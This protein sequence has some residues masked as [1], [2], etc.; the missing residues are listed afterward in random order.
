MTSP[1]AFAYPTPF[2][3][4]N[5]NQTTTWAEC[6]AFYERLAGRFPGV[7]RWWR[8]GTSDT[9]LPMHAGLVTSD[10]VFDRETLREQGRPIFF[11]NNGIHAGEPEG[12]DA[13]MALVRDFCLEPE[14]LA[15]LGKTVF[16]F[17]PVYNVDGCVNRQ[18]TSRV[19]QLG[20]E[21][22]GFRGNGLNLDLNRDF[23]KCDS[24]AAQMFNRFFTAWNPDVMVDT[25]TAN[26]ADY[27]YAMT[28]IPTQ[29]DKLGGDLGNFLRERMLPAIYGEMQRRAGRP[30]PTSICW[31]RRPTTASKIFSI[32]RASPRATPRCTTLLASCPR[33]TCSG[34]S[35]TVWPRCAR[36]SRW[37]WTSA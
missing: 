35:P 15:A 14:R 2:E 1:T 25:H 18:S 33:H 12:I 23:I 30:A 27:V 20:P 3:L 22:F 6:I 7:L 9:G 16:L 29:P 31:P 19:N 21:S 11:N 24:L 17:I 26:G 34:L 4:G 28:L 37:C 5:G 36:C 13:C 8:V 10:G 32:C